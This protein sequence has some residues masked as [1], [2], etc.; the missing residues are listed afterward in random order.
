MF[1][2]KNKL[3]VKYYLPVKMS[4]YVRIQFRSNF[5]VNRGGGYPH[6]TCISLMEDSKL[7]S[8]VN[9]LDF[10]Y[11]LLK[12]RRTFN[13]D[14]QRMIQTFFSPK[15]STFLKGMRKPLRSIFWRKRSLCHNWT[16]FVKLPDL[17]NMP[18]T[19]HIVAAHVLQNII[20]G[21]LFLGIIKFA[22]RG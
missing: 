13:F 12:F 21:D 10:W 18:E 3:L 22:R 2:K 4:S 11:K 5:Q 19:A 17:K 16:I 6:V 14:T 15:S 9:V 7:K 8:S 20:H 1:G